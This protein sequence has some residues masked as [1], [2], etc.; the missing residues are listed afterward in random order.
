MKKVGRRATNACYNIASFC[1]SPC[2]CLHWAHCCSMWVWIATVLPFHP[3]G[4]LNISFFFS[5]FIYL[6]SF[7]KCFGLLLHLRNVL[8]AAFLSYKIQSNNLFL[9]FSSFIHMCIHCLGHFPPL[10]LSTPPSLPKPPCFQ[11]EPVLPLSLILL[12]REHK[13]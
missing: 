9:L 11:A 12:E 10:P 7:Q 2:V 5:L 4:L 6:F 8:I 3:T 13:Q 1:N